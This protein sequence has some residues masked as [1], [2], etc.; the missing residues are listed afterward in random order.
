RRAA[1][2]ASASGDVSVV[3]SETCSSASA[4]GCAST[5]SASVCVD[6]ATVLSSCFLIGSRHRATLGRLAATA[7]SPGA[8]G[9]PRLLRDLLDREWDRLLPLEQEIR[10]R[11]NLELTEQVPAKRFLGQL[12]LY[13]L[14]HHPL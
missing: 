7:A 13:P 10:A 12:A 2:R 3:Y 8:D 11:L 6:S 14:L 1:G 5:P 4:P 9:W